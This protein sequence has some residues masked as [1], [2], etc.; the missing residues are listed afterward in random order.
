ML[1]MARRSIFPAMSAYA[2]KLAREALALRDIGGAF[3]AGLTINELREAI[4]QLYAYC[5]FPRC[6]NGLAAL[7]RVVESRRK[8]GKAAEQGESNT[9]IPADKSSYDLGVEVQ[10]KLFNTPSAPP[11]TRDAPSDQIVNYYLR[12]HLFGDIFARDLLEPKTRELVT[13][14]ALS[15]MIGTE[16]QLASHK[17]GALN[18]G[19]AQDKIDAA[20]GLAQKETAGSEFGLG[21]PNTAYAKYFIGKS[22]LKALPVKS[23]HISNV[24]FEPGCRNNWHVHHKTGQILLCTAGRG[25]YQEWGKEAQALKPGDVV[26][27]PPEVKHWHGA[28]KDSWFSHIAESLPVDGA[29]NEWLE[30]VTDEEYAYISGNIESNSRQLQHYKNRLQSI[31]A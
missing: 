12:T 25:W 2:A 14:A 5:G 9:P 15:S 24:T 21:E 13:N 11:L 19:L 20:V 3:E 26:D 6:L 30:P 7:E 4:V 31:D 18:A 27:I 17:K 8:Q 23:V 10:H 29:T 16:A 28:A 22:Y 1:K